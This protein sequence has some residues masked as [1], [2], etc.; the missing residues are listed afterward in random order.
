MSKT[1]EAERRDPLSSVIEIGTRKVTITILSPDVG[2]N[3]LVGWPLGNGVV[4]DSSNK[5]QKKPWEVS[6]V[7]AP[8]VFRVEGFLDNGVPASFRLS[9]GVSSPELKK[10]SVGSVRVTKIEAGES[11]EDGGYLSASLLK[12]IA[13]DRVRDECLRMAAVR[14]QLFPEG[15]WDLHNF[16]NKAT[17][18][19]WATVKVEKGMVEP[20]NVLWGVN[21]LNAKE[22]ALTT[23]GKQVNRWKSD[24]VLKAVARLFDECPPI[25]NRAK[26]IADRLEEQGFVTTRGTPF[27]AQTV[28]SQ[29]AQARSRGF[30]KPSTRKQATK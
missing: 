18:E 8:S 25:R 16:P 26:W 9:L 12:N 10:P 21:A 24:D 22:W 29:I 13:L 15:Q 14:V 4:F 20:A 28:N 2:E 19:T 6:G 27:T 5:A 7:F 3:Y 11:D 30:I 1:K 17:K 23:S